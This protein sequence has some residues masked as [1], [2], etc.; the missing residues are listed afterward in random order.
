MNAGLKNELAELT[1]MF[2]GMPEDIGLPAVPVVEEVCLKQTCQRIKQ[3]WD[4][5]LFADV[6]DQCLQRYFAFHLDGICRLSDTV[7]TASAVSPVRA[8]WRDALLELTD[9][10]LLN[11]GAYIAHAAK[12]PVVYLDR[13]RRQYEEPCAVLTKK[14]QESH[15]PPAL[16]ACLLTYIRQ[17]SSSL[18]HLRWSFGALNYFEAFLSALSSFNFLDPEEEAALNDQL[19]WLN[20]ND[21]GFFTYRQKV[22]ES[23]CASLNR[24]GQI[25]YLRTEL[26]HLR[27]LV[28]QRALIY[29]PDWPPIREMLRQTL[30]DALETLADT[31][32]EHNRSLTPAEKFP[33]NLSVSQLA[34]LIK[35]LYDEG[36][37]ATTNLSEIFRITA[38]SFRTKR[39]EQISAGSLSKEFYSTSQVTAAVVRD[40]LLKMVSRINRNFFPVWFVISATFLWH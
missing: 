17:M 26:S 37:I 38:A 19:M 21:L 6:T 31:V 22:L 7:S 36:L 23:Q 2:T 28:P 39:Q 35:L 24:A 1:G 20:F 15:L 4:D 16:R 12:V 5:A 29:H 11:Q 25:A 40:K 10:L 18:P 13:W 9:H 32:A 34:C 33:L 3:A 30:Q 8:V 27:S 14:L